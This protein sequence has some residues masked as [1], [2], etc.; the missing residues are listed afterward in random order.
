[1]NVFKIQVK[2]RL[3]L[4]F[5]RIFKVIFYF[6][7]CFFLRRKG[8]LSVLFFSFPFFRFSPLPFSSLFL[9]ALSTLL[10]FLLLHILVL[11]ISKFLLSYFSLKERIILTCVNGKNVSKNHCFTQTILRLPISVLLVIFVLESR[12]GSLEREKNLSSPFR[13]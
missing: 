2:S 11:T 6:C 1:M 7:F 10:L 5:V 12:I 13:K 8:K 4:M 9:Q 3:F